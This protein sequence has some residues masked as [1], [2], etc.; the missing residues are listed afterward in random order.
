M[1]TTEST[2]EPG[3]TPPVRPATALAVGV[4]AVLAASY[5]VN[6]ADRQVF[7]VLLKNING[8]YGSRSPKVV[9][10]RPSSRSGSGS[11]ASL[12]VA[13]WTGSR[14]SR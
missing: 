12:R 5:I 11:A 14:A 6:A 13:C 9:S 10:S 1:P 3:L 7:P 8:D 4:L 2:S